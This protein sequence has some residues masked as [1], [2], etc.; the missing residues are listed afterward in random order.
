M[1]YKK[2]KELVDKGETQTIDYKIECNAF[3]KGSEKDTAELV[4]DIIAFAN[5]GNVAS[6]LV[7]GVSNDRNGFKSVE[8]VKLTDDNLQV[9]VRDNIFPIPKVKLYTCS[10]SKVAD[11]R[12]KDKT[13]VIIQV[14]PQA[15]QCFRFNRD[16]VK[17]ENK[18]CFKRNEVW[19]RRQATS[20]LASPEEIKRLLEGKEPLVQELVE[21]NTEYSRVSRHEFRKYIKDDLIKFLPSIDATF[22]EEKEDFGKLINKTWNILTIN[23]D[24]MKLNLVVLFVERCAEKGLIAKLCREISAL[25][26]GVLLISVGNIS[27]SSVEWGPIKIKEP[28]GWF[29]TNFQTYIGAYITGLI[30]NDNKFDWQESE[31]FCIALEKVENTQDLQTKLV[32]AIKSITEKEDLKAYVKGIYDHMNKCLLNWRKTDCLVK[33]DKQLYNPD[34]KFYIEGRV[35]KTLK[36]GQYVIPKKFGDTILIKD[37]AMCEILDKFL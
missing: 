35:V 25:H 28:W 33:T 10:W 4:K 34:R 21:N 37:L 6:Y 17:Y 31:S 26:H 12:H 3:T 36:P 24:G 32:Q 2:F 7:I 29:C 22:R 8:N 11:P 18:Y 23:I 14:G 20:D 9:L 5:N 13:F 27:K 16:M 30:T 15:R 19:I 1:D